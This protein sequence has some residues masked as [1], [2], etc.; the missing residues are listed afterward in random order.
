MSLW[1]AIIV[2]LIS[3]YVMSEVVDKHFIKSLDNIAHWFKMPPDVAGATLLALGTSAPEISTALIALLY[4]GANPATGIGT[5][6]GSAIFQILVVIGFAATV[7][8]SQLSWR[9]VLRDSIFYAVSVLLLIWAVQDHRF[10]L[11]ESIVLVSF[12]FVYLF[13]L[14]LWTKYVSHAN[15]QEPHFEDHPYP[16]NQIEKE[17]EK[18]NKGRKHP[19]KLI[20]KALNAP[21]DLLL[22]LIPDVEKKPSWTIPVFIFSLAVIGYASFWLVL[23]AEAMAL[24]LNI[25]T[26]I[27]ALTILAGGTSIPEVIS[28]AIVSKQGRGDMAIANAIGSNI[29]DIVMS[30]GLPLMIY[31]ILKGE[32]VIPASDAKSLN[33]S[34]L[35]LFVSLI[36]VVGFLAALRFKATKTFGW[37][38]IATYAVYVW[39]AY[40]GMV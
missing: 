10:T 31:I 16:M 35:L 20:Q 11:F 18:E 25:P 40:S 37:T 8:V 7:R 33:Y 5:I 3:F 34:I 23:A 2:I 17:L 19:I 28:S 1:F 13:A 26:A 24:V 6:V 39:A 4:E 9:P 32:L 27:I 29:F 30:L 14:Y 22:G 21:L 15:P 38:L 36:F 12:Y